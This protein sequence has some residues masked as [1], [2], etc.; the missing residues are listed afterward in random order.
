MATNKAEV[1]VN[2]DVDYAIIQPG[3]FYR[4]FIQRFGRVSR[5]DVSG[6]I[7]VA[8]KENVTF[9]KLKKAITEKELSYYDFL[10][11]AK[12]AFQSK[13]FYTETIPSYIG[14]DIWCIRQ[15]IIEQKQNWNTQEYF[16]KEIERINLSGN[17]KYANRY[18]L[19][20]SIKIGRAHV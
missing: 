14:E 20:Q 11:I 15:N 12:K 17:S 7:V 16:K 2:Y 13:T 19:F 9:N 5:G 8:V 3:K 10:E 1:G 18:N 6:K 4:N